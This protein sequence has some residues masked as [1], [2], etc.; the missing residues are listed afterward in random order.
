[1]QIL[2]PPANRSGRTTNEN[3][4][5]LR[6]VFGD[7]SALLTGDLEKSGEAELLAE[8]QN[9]HSLLLKVAHHGS[10][11]ATL[12]PFLE[13]VRPR[14]AILSVGRNNPFGHPSREVL[15]RLLRL[16]VR[17]LS[18]LDQGA[19]TF[20]TD[21]RH[22]IIESHVCGLLEKGTLHSPKPAFPNQK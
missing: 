22:Y 19:I 7:F 4:V 14:W 16:G 11:S 12:D 21:G 2:N 6:L 3:S 10:R 1:M 20:E 9:L 18:T 15:L 17:P 8:S 13:K 5:V